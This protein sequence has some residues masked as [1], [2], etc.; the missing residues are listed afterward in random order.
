ML[1]L[2]LELGV[3]ESQDRGIHRDVYLR[4]ASLAGLPPASVPADTH[5]IEPLILAFIS[6]VQL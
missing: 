6:E 1:G 5:F 2:G 4:Y 3:D